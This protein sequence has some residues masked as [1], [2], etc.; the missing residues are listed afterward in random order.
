MLVRRGRLG[1]G[2]MLSAGGAL[3]RQAGAV[4]DV[5]GKLAIRGRFSK[6]EAVDFTAMP[7]NTG[8]DFHASQQFPTDTAEA[9][10]KLVME[11]TLLGFVSLILTAFSS[12][13][14]HMCGEP[15]CWPSCDRVGQRYM[16]SGLLLRSPA[17]WPAAAVL[18]MCDGCGVVL[19]VLVSLPTCG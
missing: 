19:L 14:S 15:P 17:L 6:S 16:L 10:D 3:K 12:P 9:L 8:I 4:V 13:L 5:N 18:Q 11:L 2:K 7:S 1:M